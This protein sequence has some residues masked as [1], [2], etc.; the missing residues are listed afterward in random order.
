MDSLHHKLSQE[1]GI[2]PQQISAV[3][4]LLEDGNTIPFIARYRKEATG[5]LSDEHIAQIDTR[6]SELKDLEKRRSA[7]CKSLLERDLLDSELQ[8]KIHK[9]TTL[10]SLEDI[11][12]PF[13]PKRRTRAEIAREKGLEPLAQTIFNFRDDRPLAPHKFIS[14]KAGITTED[15]ALNGACDIIAE[16]I[17]ENITVRGRLRS[18]FEKRA[19]ISATGN[20][21]AEGAEKFRDYFKH[22]ENIQRVAGH[23]IL[24]LFRGEA[25]SILKISV[26]PDPSEALNTL[27]S[28][29]SHK[30]VA[31]KV[32]IAKAVEDSYKRLLAPSLENELRTNLKKQAD[33]EA[34]A[35]F[36]ANFRKL[37]L[38]PALGEKRVLALDPGFRTGAKLVCLG[39]QGKLLAHSTIFPLLSATKAQE[40][41]VEIKDLVEKY[42][43]EAIAIGNG[44]AGR[45]TEAFVRD[46]F[47]NGGPLVTMVNESG[48]SVYSAS[49]LA[50]EEFPDHDVT[51]RG[52]ISIGRRLQDPLA[53]LVKIDP[54]AIGVGQYQHD[55][56]QTELKSALE[57]TVVHCVNQVGVHLNT[58]SYSLLSFVSGIGPALAKNIVTYREEVGM[59][60]SRKELQKV[61]RLGAKAY[62]QSAGFMRIT[63]GTNILDST[64]VHPEQYK[65]VEKMARD[66]HV[67]IEEFISNG[68]LRRNLVLQN[69]VSDKTGL[70]T[71]KDIMEELDQPGRDPRAQ[72][73]QFSFAQGIDKITDLEPEMVLPGIV[74]NVTAFGAFVDIGVHQDG[75]I[76]ISQLAQ[77]FI[78]DA[79][80][81]VQVQQ[82]VKV[83]VLEVDTKRKRIALSLKNVPQ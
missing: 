37:L 35:V 52:A 81:V 63:D 51:V 45:E 41:Q 69:Y 10:T 83:Q 27:H 65:V 40:A 30:N 46:L 17:N 80:E 54:K 14:I 68:E 62:E 53:E 16:W 15:D 76:H 78:K 47:V 3:A 4:A 38:S 71:L 2:Q 9:A 8:Q 21:K 23:R 26:R 70:I 82:E 5:S 58:A 12:L 60:K 28:Q 39:A 32:L 42:D 72:W 33:N 31:K 29:F 77:R 48:A 24:A 75:L 36:V 49:P 56:Q 25:L 1:L 67:S 74:T 43:I 61:P 18:L 79:S 59:F 55:V 57:D 11:Y 34:I 50:R 22:Q 13:R 6:L 19:L 66:N 73:S 7:I 64:A 44:T 20:D